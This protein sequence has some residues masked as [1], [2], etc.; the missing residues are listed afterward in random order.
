[1]KSQWYCTRVAISHDWKKLLQRPYRTCDCVV[2]RGGVCSHQLSILLMAK[3]LLIVMN[4]LSVKTWKE[5]KNHVPDHIILLQKEPMTVKY[6][7]GHGSR[8]R[9]AGVSVG[10]LKALMQLTKS[11]PTTTADAA[12]APAPATTA[13]AA[14]VLA[15]AT[16]RRARTRHI[17][18]C[19]AWGERCVRAGTPMAVCAHRGCDRTAHEVCSREYVL[20][21]P[22]PVCPLH[23]PRVTIPGSLGKMKPRDLSKR[24]CHLPQAWAARWADTKSL[25]GT[26]RTWG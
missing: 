11:T 12:S 2:R 9:F 21:C 19:C 7:Y 4:R 24:V 6:A 26:V 16:T 17:T 10:H 22:R 5:V 25:P 15:P 14:S 20:S 13:D 8:N 3:T 1:M 23:A 18:K